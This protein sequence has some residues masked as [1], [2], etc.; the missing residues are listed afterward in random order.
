MLDCKTSTSTSLDNCGGQ[1]A[2]IGATRC[3]VTCENT[4]LLETQGACG[5]V[6]ECSADTVTDDTGAQVEDVT[7]V[8][9]GVTVNRLHVFDILVSYT[10]TRSDS[11]DMA[12]VWTS[13]IRILRA[14]LLLPSVFSTFLCLL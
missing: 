3:S 13:S 6:R 7:P 4:V 8:T 14:F 11:A 12:G 9:L 10:R 1:F 2:V 5:S